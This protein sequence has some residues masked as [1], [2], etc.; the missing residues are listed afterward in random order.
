MAENKKL[1]RHYESEEGCLIFDDTTVEK[2]YTDENGIVCRYYDHGKGRNVKGINI[3]TAFYMSENEYGKL[4]TPID[5]QIISKTKTKKDEKSGKERRASGKTKNEM[6]REMTGQT[7][8]KHVKFGSIL[9]DSWFSSAENMVFI[10][11][12]KKMFIYIWPH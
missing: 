10:Q 5:Y 7:I 12:K 1:V 2:A 3:L 9:A 6:M 11:G 4:Q 8:Q